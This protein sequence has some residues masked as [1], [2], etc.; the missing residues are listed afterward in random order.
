MRKLIAGVLLT[1][2]A[3]TVV[4][5]VD[6]PPAD[7]AAA[8]DME[9]P[10]PQLVT[11][12]HT[13]A[14]DGTETVRSDAPATHAP[15]GENIAAVPY[16][17]NRHYGRAQYGTQTPVWVRIDDSAIFYVTMIQ[18]AVAD[19]T[20]SSTHAIYYIGKEKCPRQ[21]LLYEH[22]ITFAHA[23][24]LQCSSGITYSNARE[25][26]GHWHMTNALVA[27]NLSSACGHSLGW[28]QFVVCHE[29]GHAVGLSHGS[30]Q[31]A[32]CSGSTRP[33]LGDIGVLNYLGAHSHDGALH[34]P[35]GV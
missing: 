30:N 34:L 20:Q 24:N 16:G 29:G 12:V 27:V 3:F 10:R 1:F 23:G 8:P 4:V 13:L 5:G 21:G 14:A 18:N 2:S 15:H 11:E 6:A 28:A 19:W 35:H 32:P 22:C 9:T 7:D 33:L 31:W 26:F 25:S 17:D